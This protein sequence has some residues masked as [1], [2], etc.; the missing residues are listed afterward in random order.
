MQHE[1]GHP[2]RSVAR[3]LGRVG[4]WTFETDRMSAVDERAFVAEVERL[5]YPA[6]WI[7]ESVP[8]KEIFAHLA[9]LLAASERL[10]IASGIANI[11]AHDPYAMAN[12]SRALADAYPGR[13]VLGIGVS[14]A[15][16]VKRR[17]GSYDRPLQ[18]MREYLDL[19]DAA[20][21]AGPDPADPA[22]L[23]LAALGPRM[24]ELAAER[25]AGVH[26]YFVPVE[27]T[28]MARSTV[29][30][31]P[32]IATEQTVVL[33]TDATEARR[34]A[35]AFMGRYLKL[36][37]YA[38]N[39]RRLGWTDDDIANDGSDALVD[40]IVAWGD[41]S[42]IAARVRAHLDGGADHV[43]IQAL[44]TDAMP[45]TEQLRALAPALL[46]L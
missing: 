12:G 29:G 13:L 5:G 35:R 38:N 31:G 8:S 2:G 16:A 46:A 43:C 41:E 32:L 25:S 44:R 36:A 6:L 18:Q 33:E 1:A 19:M 27:H 34:V 23:V 28:R 11:H 7:P 10:V 39:L 42:A 20:A 17:G 3:K 22:P 4:V 40:A 24:L 30:P 21:Y 15:P 26:P 45:L 14:H 9:L 37:N